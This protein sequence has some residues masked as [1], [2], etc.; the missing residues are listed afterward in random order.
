MGI[1]TITPSFP[2]D[3]S[4]T[5]SSSQTYGFLSSEGTVGT[6]SGT[7]SY[8]IRATGRILAS[9]FNAVSDAR[10][11]DVQ[12]DID[13]TVALGLITELHPVSFT[14][15]DNPDGQPVLGFLA[16]EVEEVIPNAVSK[17][18]TDQFSDQR[19]LSYNQLT[20]VSIAAIQGMNIRIKGLQELTDETLLSKLR[21][22][23]AS[24]S[25]GIT[26]FFTKK[27]HTEELCIKKSDGGEVCVTGDQIETILQNQNIQPSGNS[28][29]GGGE[30]VPE[31]IG[32]TPPSEESIPTIEP[33]SE[34]GGELTPE[35]VSEL[36]PEPVV[37]SVS[38]E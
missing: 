21:D 32:E 12:F 25:N 34:L 28:D 1:G 36:T 22:W 3:V 10:L 11:K 14:W 17:I 8:S 15:K 26:D 19:E 9:E 30:S 20:A 29:S 18:K 13:P 6:S 35:V 24:A 38:T 5:V 37:E 7:S 23:F 4:S 16:Q 2:L 33:S 27:V 31:V